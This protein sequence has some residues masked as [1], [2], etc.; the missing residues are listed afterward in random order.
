MKIYNNEKQIVFD[1]SINK[2]EKIKFVKYKV[3]AKDGK[4]IPCDEKVVN[5]FS[6]GYILEFYI[7]KTNDEKIY[8]RYVYEKGKFCENYETE[9]E[10]PKR[11]CK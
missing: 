7:D 1:L 6:D 10:L 11:R 2:D 3:D 4:E 9:K 8:K 5:E